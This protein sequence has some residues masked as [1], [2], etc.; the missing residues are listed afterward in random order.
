V[1]SDQ[2]LIGLALKSIPLG[3]SDR[4]ITVLSD[5]KGISRLAVP[6]ARRSKSSLAGANP[7]TLLDIEVVGKNKL[8]KVRQIR[9][10]HNYGNVSRSLEILS[11]AQALT[12]LCL[13]LVPE[14]DPI[15]GM[16]PTVLMHLDRLE[17]TDELMQDLTTQIIAETVQSSMH[18][19]ALG[20][21]GLPIQKC[22][23]SESAL[24]P[25]IGNWQ[26][27]CSFIPDSG[28]AIGS[29]SESPIQLNPSE[30]ALMQRLM[31]KDLPICSNGKL[32]GPLN[33]WAKLFFVIELWINAHLT[34]KI[35]SFALLKE[36]F[37]PILS[38]S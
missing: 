20:G 24:E 30:L 22:C 36:C 34:K 29:I 5:M 11:S 1:S 18:I 10:I 12:E 31:R 15:K 4:L 28:F 21:Y 14:N 7:L 6:G 19:L 8:K 23:L 16:L 3:E 32:M 17:K 35:Q 2:S 25:P 27:S 37:M 26:W 33:A 9:L 38:K 13:L